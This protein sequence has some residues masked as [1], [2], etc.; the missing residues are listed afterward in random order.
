MKMKAVVVSL[1]SGI[2]ATSIAGFTPVY[3]ADEDTNTTDAMQ[4][5]ENDVQS[6]NM[7]QDATDNGSA[8]KDD[9]A[10]SSDDNSSDGS[11]SGSRNDEATPHIATRDHDY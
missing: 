9:A 2:L 4:L 8:K 7:S 1:L 11:T 6:G 10:D 5:A 3:A